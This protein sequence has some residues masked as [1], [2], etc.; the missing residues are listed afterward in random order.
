MATAIY[1]IQEDALADPQKEWMERQN[2]IEL[3]FSYEFDFNF[4]ENRSPLSLLCWW[5]PGIWQEVARSMP[6]KQFH[7]QKL[8][9]LG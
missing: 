2:L 7:F 4:P 5:G 6:E 3:C 1:D 8:E 9:H